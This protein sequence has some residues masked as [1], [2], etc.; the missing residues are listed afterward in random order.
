MRPG[1]CAKLL[2]SCPTLWDPMD[3]SPPVFCPWDSLGK[4]TEWVVTTSSRGSSRPRDCTHVSRLLP[5]QVGSLP[6]APP[7]KPLY[8]GSISLIPKLDNDITR[9]RQYP[10]WITEN[11]PTNTNKLNLA[12]TKKDY[13]WL[14]GIYPR[15]ARF[16][17]QKS[18]E[19]TIL[20]E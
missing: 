3:C 9:K 15:N 11:F 2:Q 14:S 8:E 5:W 19:H 12:T 13:V 16:N 10:L 20:I 6:V 1:V 18:M 4:N 7:G 17:T